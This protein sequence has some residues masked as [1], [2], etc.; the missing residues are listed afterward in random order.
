MP[1]LVRL[2]M[3]PICSWMVS[4]LV[5][6]ACTTIGQHATAVVLAGVYPLAVIM[7]VRACVPH[8]CDPLYGQC[9]H[10]ASLRMNCSEAF[11]I[12]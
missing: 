4:N 5:H 2:L 8:Q 3:Q 6:G 9:H 11:H 1:E 7:H 12:G 10:A